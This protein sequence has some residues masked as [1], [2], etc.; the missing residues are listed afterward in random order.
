MDTSQI[1]LY[2]M[3]GGKA[4]IEVRLIND[5]GCLTDDTIL[6]RPRGKSGLG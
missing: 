6:Q 1:T 4:K 5:T 2:Q 3:H